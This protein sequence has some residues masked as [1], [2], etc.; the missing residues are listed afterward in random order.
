LFS[1]A[2]RSP[3]VGLMRAQPF[4]RLRLGDAVHGPQVARHTMPRSA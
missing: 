2:L 1:Y 3:M 4:D